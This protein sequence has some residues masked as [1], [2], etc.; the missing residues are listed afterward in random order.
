MNRLEF[1]AGIAQADV[2]VVRSGSDALELRTPTM[3][4]RIFARL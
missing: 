3:A 2:S 4:G 1:G